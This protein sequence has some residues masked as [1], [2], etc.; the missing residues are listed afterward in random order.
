LKFEPGNNLIKMLLHYLIYTY[1]I[2]F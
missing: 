2:V 1:V